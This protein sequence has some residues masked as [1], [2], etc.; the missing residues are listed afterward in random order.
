MEWSNVFVPYSLFLG[1]SAI[2]PIAMAMK[3]SSVSVCNNRS[4]RSNLNENQKCKNI[5]FIDFDI[6]NLSA[7]L[8]LL[9]SATLTCLDAKF[10][11]E[12]AIADYVR[13]LWS[14][15]GGVNGDI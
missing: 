14:N 4:H 8:P 6:C 11:A 7:T 1:K 13:R 2:V 12:A 10:D 15:F 9:H 3:C 5:T